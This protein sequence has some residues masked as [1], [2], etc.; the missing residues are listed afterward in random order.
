M[1][2]DENGNIGI[3]TTSPLFP[4]SVEGDSF[5][6]GNLVVTGNSTTTNA[7]TTDLHISSDLFISDDVISDFNG[8]GL[9]ITAGVL[10]LN[11]TGDWTGTFDGN[12]FGGG[13]IGVNEMLYGSSAGVLGEIS[14]GTSGQLLQANGS[15]VPVFVTLSSD[16][17]I[18]AGGA[19]TIAGNAVALGTDTTGNYAATVADSG[20]GTLTVGGSGSETAAITVGINL[21]NANAWTALQTFTNASSTQLSAAS[22]TFYIDSA[23]RI[24]AKD[25]TQNK[26]GVISPLNWLAFDYSTS[27]WAGTTT[28]NKI[29]VPFAGTLQSVRC[30]TDAGTVDVNANVNSN[31]LFLLTASTTV[32]QNDYSTSNTFTA[33]QVLTLTAGNPA[34]SPTTLSCTYGATETY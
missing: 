11:A 3:A 22:Q 15:G 21:A 2:I 25:T 6:L 34:S 12:N 13:A 20:G 10:T 33:G 32:N 19:L 30:S 16:A 4:L 24:Q 31:D 23:G 27:T 17:T 14:A 1:R 26:S 18:A 7:T 8:A 29:V 5:L 9:D 28:I